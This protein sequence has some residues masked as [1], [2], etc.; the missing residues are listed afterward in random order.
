MLR[1]KAQG[2]FVLE[3]TLGKTKI[4]TT[5]TRLCKSA[6]L[7]QARRRPQKWKRHFHPSFQRLMNMKVK[8]FFFP[9]DNIEDVAQQSPGLARPRAYPG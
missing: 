6:I 8:V 5:S 3:P 9:S 1:N 4:L 2:W 7:P